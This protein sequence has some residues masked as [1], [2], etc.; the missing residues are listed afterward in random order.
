VAIGELHAMAQSLKMGGQGRFILLEFQVL[1]K[2]AQN[3]GH[4]LHAE[5]LNMSKNDLTL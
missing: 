4:F 2:K 1:R 3:L 5:L